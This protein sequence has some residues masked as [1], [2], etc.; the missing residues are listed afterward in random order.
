MIYCFILLLITSITC[1]IAAGE[2]KAENKDSA[3]RPVLGAIMGV[4]F[5]FGAAMELAAIRDADHKSVE[6]KHL[7]ETAVF[8]LKQAQIEGRIVD[9]EFK[10]TCHD[11]SIITAFERI[12]KLEGTKKTGEK[13]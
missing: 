12:Q 8:K 10:D 7:C 2:E 11:Q 6:D 13:N 4:M 1:F 3:A 9:L 5:L